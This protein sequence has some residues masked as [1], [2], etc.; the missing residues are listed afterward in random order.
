V[1]WKAVLSLSVPPELKEQL[2]RDAKRLGLS[3]NALA[4]LRLKVNYPKPPD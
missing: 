2:R 4:N 3:M 1:T